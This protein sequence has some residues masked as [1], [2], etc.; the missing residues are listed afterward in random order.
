MTSGAK[1]QLLGGFYGTA[2]AVPLSETAFG[3]ASDHPRLPTDIVISQL[4][5]L[6]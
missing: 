1:A 3:H 2:E 4:I 5:P 6:V